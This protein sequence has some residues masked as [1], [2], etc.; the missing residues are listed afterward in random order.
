MSTNV[1]MELLQNMSD[2][3]DMAIRL[4]EE[5]TRLGYTQADFAH[6]TNISREGLRLYESGQRGISAEFLAQS[7]DLGIDVQYIL[8]GLRSQ[9]LPTM[10]KAALKE[11][12]QSFNIH[13]DMTNSNIINGSNSTINNIK[14]ESYKPT[15]KATPDPDI[16][17]GNEMAST[18]KRLVEEIVELE[19]KLKKNP[20]SYRAV[21]AS[22]NKHMKAPSY[23]F[24]EKD[25]QEQA[26][27]Y[28]KKWIG[29]LS[30]MKSAPK[31]GSEWR[32]RKYAYI[33]I[34]TKSGLEDWLKNLL[35]TKYCV[36]SLSELSDDQLTKVY[37]SVASKKKRS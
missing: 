14:T 3:I 11:K 30:S 17:I 5:R 35:E 18:L 15:Y 29:R 2:R 19:Q 26:Y 31:L 33:K 24:I 4:V 13:G 25:S 28:L 1:V 22:L 32:K 21:W 10:E 27:E 8:I 23:R 36:G 20:K 37:N 16:H 6:Q 12:E 7:A 9:N 34:N